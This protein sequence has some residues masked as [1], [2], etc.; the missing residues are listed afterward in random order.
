MVFKSLP[1]YFEHVHMQHSEDLF[2]CEHCDKEFV[3]RY[4][5][6]NHVKGV[7][8]G[9]KRFACNT[10]SETFSVKSTLDSHVLSEHQNNAIEADHISPMDFVACEIKNDNQDNDQVVN[11]RKKNVY[12]KVTCD[13]CKV[14]IAKYNISK[15][16]S[17]VHGKKY[18]FDIL[19]T[20]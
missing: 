14:L 4:K 15:H 20:L 1:D 9:L 19:Q 2:K 6:R 16:M 5:L 10:C 17:L 13:F 3:H 8:F 7:H 12:E 18:S 11:T